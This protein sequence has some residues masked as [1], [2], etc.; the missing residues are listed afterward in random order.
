MTRLA[1]PYYG[2][3]QAYPPK[4]ASLWSGSTSSAEAFGPG[5]LA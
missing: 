4:A 5:K 3:P 1:E 2:R